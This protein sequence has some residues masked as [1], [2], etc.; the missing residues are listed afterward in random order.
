M[1]IVYLCNRI[2]NLRVPRICVD[3]GDYGAQPKPLFLVWNS[4]TFRS[5]AQYWLIPTR[6]TLLCWFELEA[7]S[8][9]YVPRSFWVIRIELGYSVL[10]SRPSDPLPYL[11]DHYRTI[12]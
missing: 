3:G 9:P 5:L 4:F 2:D 8:L 11:T 12:P 1:T 7:L 10:S 6:N